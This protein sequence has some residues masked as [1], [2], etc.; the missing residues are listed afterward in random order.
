MFSNVALFL[1]LP[2]KS[3]FV[4]ST[5]PKCYFPS[6]RV[7]KI[8]FQFWLSWLWATRVNGR[9]ASQ[10]RLSFSIE[11][12]YQDFLT[13][14]EGTTII[15]HDH[16][17]WKCARNKINCIGVYVDFCLIRYLSKLSHTLPKMVCYS[18]R[19][20]LTWETIRRLLRFF[21]VAN[22]WRKSWKVMAR[23]SFQPW[24]NKNKKTRRLLV[25]YRETFL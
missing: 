3:F 19:R 22:K 14:C 16:V 4:Q 17:F 9:R 25:N 8:F 13:T 20:L 6:G 23:K 18:F 24:T 21:H 10:G 5:A 7:M 11:I 1:F 2:G 15:R 12:I